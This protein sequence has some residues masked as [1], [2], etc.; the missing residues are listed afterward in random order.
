MA[1]KDTSA[2]SIV[3]EFRSGD[4]KPLY[5]FY[6]DEGFFIDELQEL[7]IRTALQP[8]EK[9]FNLDLF[10]GPEAD[11]RNVLAACASFPMMSERRV[12][13]VRAF[14][15]LADN[16]LF[17]AYASGPNPAAIVLLI[18]QNKPNLT[19]HPYRAL[20]KH[21]VSVEFS[22]LREW[23][24]PKWL[25][26]RA[27]K[28]GL[29]IN[30]KAAQLLAHEIGTD[31]RAADNELQKLHVYAGERTTITENDVIEAAGQLREFS[32]FELQKAV[33]EIDRR[34]ATAIIDKLLQ[35]AGDERGE[36]IRIVNILSWYFQKLRLLAGVHAQNLSQEDRAKLLGGMSPY[37]LKEFKA[38][39]AKL[40]PQRIRRGL[41]YVL[42]ADSEL[43]GQST[44]EPRL[45]LLLTVGRILG[46]P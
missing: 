18:C 16:D 41:K 44:L 13:V 24:M 34:R 10:F 27:K 9:D 37:Q 43:K 40:G 8:H 21:A 19:K 7:L 4:F 30:E 1:K 42:T 28:H 20:N 38:A 32:V 22:A 11:A 39:S 15:S 31:L 45:I 36:A 33:G 5:F 29:Q 12:V 25:I 23:Q 3:A 14:E 17:T 35:Q 6:G 46:E 26:Q 2:D